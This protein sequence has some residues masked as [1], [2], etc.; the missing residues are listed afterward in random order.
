MKRLAGIL[1]MGV[2]A[3]VLRMVT[4][5]AAVPDLT[6]DNNALI[7]VGSPARVSRTIF[8]L[9]YRAKVTNSS[10]ADMTGVGATLTSLSPNTV[11]I[12]GGLTFGDVPV[13]QTV[14]S[15]DNFT[16]RQDRSFAFR[17]QDLVWQ[18]S[19]NP[20]PSPLLLTLSSDKT[21]YAIGEVPEF[22]LALENVSSSPVTVSTYPDANLQINL[23]R[24]DT[25][26][27]P[28]AV[29]ITM[30]LLP[31]VAASKAL[32]TLRPKESISITVPTFY[33]RFAN[34]P[35]IDDDFL[36]LR[37]VKSDASGLFALY[38]MVPLTTPGSYELQYIYKYIGDPSDPPDL[39]L[40]GVGSN[41]LSF[42]IR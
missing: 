41:T 34:L 12:K 30:R 37:A 21:D 38:Y 23:K 4:G 13:G 42:R 8:D 35:P 16:I 33:N 1:L 40:H 26:I 22:T 18:I 19:G 11:V 39:Y 24:N 10:T 2:C 25:P 14:I 15:S 3:V 20:K 5:Y 28:H 6:I 29:D 7:L 27:Q 31:G 9:T 32:I 36:K 17:P